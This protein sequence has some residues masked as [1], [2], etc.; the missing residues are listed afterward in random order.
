MSLLCLLTKMKAK[1]LA[2]SALLTAILLTA[3][4]ML[5]SLPNI[6]LVTL[7]I[8]LYTLCFKPRLTLCAVSA[9]V[10]L[11]GILYGF[12]IWWFSWIYIWALLVLLT[13]LM[14]NVKSHIAWCVFSGAFGLCFGALC[15]IPSLFAGGFYAAVSYWFNGI[16]FD[17][18]HCVGNT[19][20]MIILY[21]PL[22]KCFEFLSAKYCE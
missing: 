19:L 14:R 10:L 13:Y 12:G 22:R 15:A 8:I 9:F 18:A 2:I 3:Q 21:K 4:V 7:L 6:E 17:I 5:A 11:E 16:P 20:A 1:R